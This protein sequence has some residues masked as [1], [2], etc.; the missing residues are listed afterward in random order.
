MEQIAGIIGA[1][2]LAVLV[3]CGFRSY[4]KMRK[5]RRSDELRRNYRCLTIT[6]PAVDRECE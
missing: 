6:L 2:A 5:R 4:R 1:L 3:Y